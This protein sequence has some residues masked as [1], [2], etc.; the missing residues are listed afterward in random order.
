MTAKELIEKLNKFNPDGN[1]EVV[2]HSECVERYCIDAISYVSIEE[3]INGNLV[4]VLNTIERQTEKSKTT[5]FSNVN[6]I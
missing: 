2:N 1:M 5:C 3:D 6:M 4:I